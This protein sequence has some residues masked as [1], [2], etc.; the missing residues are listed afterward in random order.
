MR[1][2]SLTRARAN[3]ARERVD[4]LELSE[5]LGALGDFKSEKDGIVSLLSGEAQEVLSGYNG[6][7][8]AKFVANIV[9]L[10]LDYCLLTVGARLTLGK[11]ELE[12]T[13]IGKSCYEACAIFQAGEVCP[14]PNCCAFARVMH[15]GR[16]QTDDEITIFEP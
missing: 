9:T 14:L 2:A 4:A 6:L 12:I 8:T 1:I 15:G 5:H 13:R 10:G 16:I 7:C 3:A 11:A